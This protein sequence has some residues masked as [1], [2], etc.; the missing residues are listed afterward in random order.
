MNQA[1]L[2]PVTEAELRAVEGGGILRRIADAV[3]K[4]ISVVRCI[5]KFCT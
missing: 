2:R 1:Q 5:N 3:S 4:V